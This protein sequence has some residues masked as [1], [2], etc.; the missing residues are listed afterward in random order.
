MA[1][2]DSKGYIRGVVGPSVFRRAWGKNIIQSKPRKF[3]QTAASIES[4]SEFGLISST[5]ACLRHAFAPVIRYYDGRAV[6]RATSAVSASIRGSSGTLRC[7]RDLHDG[8]LSHLVGL[9]F[10][11]NS[12]LQDVLRLRAEVARDESGRVQVQLPALDMKRDLRLPERLRTKGYRMQLRFLL[13]GF[14]F[15]ENYYEYI[16]HRE[17]EYRRGK[18]SAP[19]TV[20]LDG[21]VPAGCMLLL[22]MSV[23]LYGSNG[24]DG[25]D[26][27]LNNLQFSPCALIGAWQSEEVIPLTDPNPLPEERIGRFLM[28]YSGNEILATLA[29]RMKRKAKKSPAPLSQ[30]REDPG[31]RH[32]PESS[33]EDNLSV[34]K[35]KRMNMLPVRK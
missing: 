3:K 20:A 28:A 14:N 31:R 35:G 16:G 1:I 25:E 33:R 4:S 26:M 10:N 30:S 17:L 12:P 29:A 19:Q 13:I 9:E 8:D 27:L 21:E 2:I 24:F 7:R 6:G 22:S 23:S 5:A 18:Q 11:R 15:R 32:R 34:L